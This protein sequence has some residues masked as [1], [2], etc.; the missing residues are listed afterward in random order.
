M[1]TSPALTRVTIR[2][3][4]AASR[5]EPVSVGVPLPPGRVPD[6]GR[7]VAFSG[8]PLPTAATVL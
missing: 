3:G 7:L 5:R 1:T 8:A 2:P 4:A 6:A